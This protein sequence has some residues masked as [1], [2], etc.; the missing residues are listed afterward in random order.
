MT[1]SIEALQEL[2]SE[3]AGAEELSDLALMP[4][5]VTCWFWTCFKTCSVTGG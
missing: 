1:L 5:S 2:P 3:D 4:C